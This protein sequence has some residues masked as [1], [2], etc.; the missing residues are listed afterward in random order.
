MLAELF[1]Q[2]LQALLKIG[3]HRGEIRFFV[4]FTA[5]HDVID[6]F[7]TIVGK[8]C[9]E[10]GPEATLHPIARNG[11]ADLLGNRDAPADRLCRNRMVAAATVREQ[12]KIWGD[13]S[14]AAIGSEKICALANHLDRPI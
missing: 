13:E 3:L 14:L 2:I 4:G 10:Q 8:G 9:C 7:H 1:R 11:V 5:D 6:T 12:D